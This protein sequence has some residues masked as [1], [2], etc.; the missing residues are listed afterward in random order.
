MADEGLEPSILG[1][2]GGLCTDVE[3]LGLGLGQSPLCRNVRF[4]PGFVGSRYGYS[5]FD[6]YD[7]S[8]GIVSSAPIYSFIPFV[9]RLSARQIVYLTAGEIR[10]RTMSPA[11]DISL[12]AGLQT[13]SQIMMAGASVFGKLYLTLQDCGGMEKAGA[14]TRGVSRLLVTD[15]LTIDDVAP[16]PPAWVEERNSPSL[17]TDSYVDVVAG[18]G[19]LAAGKHS[20]VWL[21]LRADGYIT[22]PGNGGYFTVT[23]GV[24]KLKCVHAPIGPPGTAARILAIT[25]AGGVNF[26]YN[27][28]STVIWDNVTRDFERLVTEAELEDGVPVM[29]NFLT[30]TPAAPAG[31]AP[32]SGRLVLWGCA[33]K[34]ECSAVLYPNYQFRGL[35]NLSFSGGFQQSTDRWYSSPYA[36]PNRWQSTGPTTFVGFGPGAGGT[37]LLISGTATGGT[38]LAYVTGTINDSYVKAGDRLVIRA[39]VRCSSGL[40]SGRVTITFALTDTSGGAA[41][42]MTATLATG[43]G[44][45]GTEWSVVEFGPS[46][47][48]SLGPP[49]LS[50]STATMTVKCTT[51]FGST[52]A[53]I[54]IDWIEIVK[55]DATQR[56][57]ALIVSNAGRPDTFDVETGI[58]SIGNGDGEGIVVCFRLRETLYV[59]KDRSLY[60]VRDTDIEPRYWPVE[61]VDAMSGT[62]TPFGVGFGDGWVVIL[63][64]IGMVYW[65]GSTPQIISQEITPTWESIDWTDPCYAWV[66]VDP[67]KKMIWAGVRTTSVGSGPCDTLLTLDY[68]EGFGN[69]VPSGVGRKWSVDTIQ[70]KSGTVPGYHMGA[71]VLNASGMPRPVFSMSATLPSATGVHALVYQTNGRVDFLDASV[72]GEGNIDAVYETAPFG[73]PIGRTLFGKII[74]R[75]AGNGTLATWLVRP[76][77]A[78]ASRPDNTG[79]WLIQRSLEA[80]PVNDTEIVAGSIDTCLGVRIQ[81]FS[82]NDW[83]VLRRMGVLLAASPYSYTRGSR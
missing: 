58:V 75:I 15:G 59:A 43:L 33:E 25:L 55:Y 12:L 39:R 64:R 9:S 47:V 50:G 28:N 46:T 51:T 32:Y 77:G 72:S 70:T 48:P 74:H 4:G 66:T 40:G 19:G 49:P 22:R 5:I 41:M 13:N 18:S 20:F 63:S 38:D 36:L 21:Y 31:C 23:A 67:A 60:A 45:V 54:E 82:R 57:N 44:T 11:S 7:Y 2:F 80:S 35:A 37:T 52:L 53:W 69:P 6:Q 3:R 29:P 61:L 78:L 42:S 24:E 1:T 83:F 26:Y 76:S 14:I 56:K 27:P 10:V 68:R 17:P 65:D 71:M 34:A 16:D 8:G 81:T 62:P 30:F 79:T 73:L